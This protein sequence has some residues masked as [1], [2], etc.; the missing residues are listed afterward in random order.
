MLVQRRHLGWRDLTGRTVSV[1]QPL[2]CL[3]DAP[4][5]SETSFLGASGRISIRV[6]RPLKGQQN[7][8]VDEGRVSGSG[9]SHLFL[10]LEDIGVGSAAVEMGLGQKGGGR[11][12]RKCPKCLRECSASINGS[13]RAAKRGGFHTWHGR[14]RSDLQPLLI[15]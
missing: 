13:W 8:Q 1:T 4:I 3:R 15:P 7:K 9:D 12:G 11:V 5:A 14:A 10:P 2:E 6:G